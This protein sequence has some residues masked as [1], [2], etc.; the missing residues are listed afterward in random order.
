MK[1]NIDKIASFQNP[2]MDY[3]L[4]ELR[5]FYEGCK[6][7]EKVGWCSEVNPLK[8]YLLIYNQKNYGGLSLMLHNLLSAIAYKTFEEV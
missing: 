6:D 1:D 7:I 4:S 2:F 5:L 8:P 3:T